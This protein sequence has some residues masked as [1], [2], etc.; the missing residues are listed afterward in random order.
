MHRVRWPSFAALITAASVTS[1]QQPARAAVEQLPDSLVERLVTPRLAPDETVLPPVFVGSL[2]PRQRTILAFTDSVETYGGFTLMDS[3]GTWVQHRL[4]W[5]AEDDVGASLDAVLFDTSPGD[6]VPRIICIVTYIYSRGSHSGEEYHKN[7]VLRWDGSQF[8]HLPDVER[9]IEQL[10]TA[11]AV[12]RV[13]RAP[14][15]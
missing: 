13:L 5:L 2:G 4:P 12:R 7:A 9:R 15:R 8:V 11:A 6:S 3:S 1:A 10:T 14:R